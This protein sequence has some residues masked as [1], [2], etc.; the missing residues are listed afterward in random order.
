MATV[1]RS[2]A[3]VVALARTIVNGLTEHG[4]HFADTPVAVDAL[5]EALV[6]YRSAKETAETH[7]YGNHGGLAAC[8]WRFDEPERGDF[9]VLLS[10]SRTP[11]D[12]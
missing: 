3:G 2:E 7:V 10:R 6:R 9:G 4:E 11:C 12:R 5:Q 1:P 8:N